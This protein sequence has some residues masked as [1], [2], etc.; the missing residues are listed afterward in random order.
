MK[1]RRIGRFYFDDYG[2]DERP[3]MARAVLAGCIV[4]RAEHLPHRQAF[5]YIAQ[6]PSFRAVP[7][8]E[9][10]PLYNAEITTNGAA[11]VIAVKWVEGHR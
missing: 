3:D 1:D 5:E 9:E 4:L 7:L 2:I 10:L 8:G 6:H 11:E